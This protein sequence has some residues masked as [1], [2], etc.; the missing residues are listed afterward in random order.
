VE[1]LAKNGLKY[2]MPLRHISIKI[3]AT[4]SKKRLSVRMIVLKLEKNSFYHSF[5]Q[6][7]FNMD[8]FEKQILYATE[9]S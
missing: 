2:F 4:Y 8:S 9:D 1:F 7:A 6:S 5:C 3:L